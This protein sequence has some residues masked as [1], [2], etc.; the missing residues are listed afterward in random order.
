MEYLAKKIIKFVKKRR[1]SK[2]RKA[3][4]VKQIAD[5]KIRFIL[6]Y[7]YSLSKFTKDCTIPHLHK[8][9]EFATVEL[10]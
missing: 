1:L 5:K 6:C 8:N 7:Q 9:N 2:R 4:R 10:T 3:N